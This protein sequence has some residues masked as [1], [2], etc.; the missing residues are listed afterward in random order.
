MRFSSVSVVVLAL[1]GKATGFVTARART[2]RLPPN[3]FEFEKM[4]KPSTHPATTWP[5]TATV[6]AVRGGGRSALRA[7]D[8]GSSRPP[9]DVK[10]VGK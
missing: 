10:A 1:F 2:G 4:A 3:A 9:L 8:A 5:Q 6:T 7:S